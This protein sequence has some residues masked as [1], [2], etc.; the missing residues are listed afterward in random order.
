MTI[1]SERNYKLYVNGSLESELTT[2]SPPAT[3]GDHMLTIG[4][5]TNNM[6]APVEDYFTGMVDSVRIYNRALSG[7]EVQALCSYGHQYIIL[8]GNAE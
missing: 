2:D 8:T 4:A 1:D 5:R 6:S 7:Y 3:I